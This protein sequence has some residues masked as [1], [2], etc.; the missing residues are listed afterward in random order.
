MKPDL[1]QQLETFTCLVYEYPCETRLYEVSA[2][3]LKK[4]VGE[5]ERMTTK[6]KE[7]LSRLPPCSNSHAPHVD[8]VNHRV[9][10]FI[11]STA[12]LQGS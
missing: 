3:M 11:R 6:F 4:M 10:L 7:M 12:A 1:Y 9:A 5:D 8:R 2:L